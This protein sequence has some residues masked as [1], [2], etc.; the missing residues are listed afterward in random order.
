M[1]HYVA[2]DVFGSFMLVFYGTWLIPIF[3]FLARLLKKNPEINNKQR[4]DTRG[5]LPDIARPRRNTRAC[6]R[7]TLIQRVNNC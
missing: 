3:G 2:P 5:T 4:S 7:I 6:D 1:F